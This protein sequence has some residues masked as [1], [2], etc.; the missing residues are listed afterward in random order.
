MENIKNKAEKI[1]IEILEQEN[2]YSLA[3]ES[4]DSEIDQI[5]LVHLMKLNKQMDILKTRYN[6]L[7]DPMLRYCSFLYRLGRFIS[8]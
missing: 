2:H 8:L 3:A 6:A 5:A 4:P 1:A 7:K